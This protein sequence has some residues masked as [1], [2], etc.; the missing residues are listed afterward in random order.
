[1]QHRIIIKNIYNF[2]KTSFTIDL[3]A[4][5]QVV[6]RANYYKKAPFIQP[7]N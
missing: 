4:T 5:T 7:G 1:M 2:N 6:I 3:V